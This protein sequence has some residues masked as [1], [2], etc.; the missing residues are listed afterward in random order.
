M[1]NLEP[2]TKR[3]HLEPRAK[4][5]DTNCD[6]VFALEWCDGCD[7]SEV[8]ISGIRDGH[9]P[10]EEIKLFC[11]DC[12]FQF[13]EDYLIDQ[14]D[15]SKKPEN[16]IYED[17]RSPVSKYRS[18]TLIDR[19]RDATKTIVSLGTCNRIISVIHCICT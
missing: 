18:R 17:K 10:L 14:V 15:K 9:Y 3:D 13:S 7:G 6:H 12:G 19:F 4:I 11:C 16:R 8:R 1:N 5:G 2:V